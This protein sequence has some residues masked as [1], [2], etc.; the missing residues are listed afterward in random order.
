MMSFPK[1]R[2]DPEGYCRTLLAGTGPERGSYQ[3]LRPIHPHSPRV[4]APREAA[5]LQGFPDW[6]Q[7]HATKW[8]AFRQLGNSVSPIVAE[9]LLA[10]IY[11]A[12]A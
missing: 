1:S 10:K 4:I 2:L 6:F 8:H 12:M 5:R 3:G 7:F 11:R 9:Y